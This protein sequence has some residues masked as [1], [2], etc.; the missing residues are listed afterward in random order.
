MKSYEKESFLKIFTIFFLT[1]VTLWGIIF[2]LYYEENKDY[3]KE[4]LYY[5]MKNYAFDFKGDKF[6]LEILKKKK[7]VT[8]SKLLNSKNGLEIYF[9]MPKE[10]NFML[11][12]KYSQKKFQS[13]LA[14]LKYKILKFAF[15]ILL[16]GF[17]FSLYFS[18]YSL[19]PMKKAISL[20]EVF[21]KDL[22]HDLHTPITS[23]LLNTK[24][25]SKKEPSQELERIELSAK[26]VSSLYKNL[27]VIK[28]RV[29]NKTEVSDIREII[30]QKIKILQKLYPKISIVSDLQ[31]YLVATNKDAIS[32]ILDNILTNACK[33][34]K[35][36]GQVKIIM[37][38]NKIV[39][40][41][42]GIGIKNPTKVFQRYYKE[43]ERGL[44]LGLNIVKKLCDELNINIDIKS[45][46]NIGT[47]VELTFN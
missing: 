4:D 16:F 11:K 34:N 42:N 15:V 12:V 31:D 23:I 5:Q 6:T 26:T 3:I 36:N 41:D 44:G 37:D 35:K 20:L 18:Y 21:L 39:I 30:I 13:D 25:L 8:F 45:K 40:K 2:Y 1:F 29:I 7:K 17:I 24:I 47:T 27:E 28:G 38:E 19:R 33:Y 14:K 9:P 46:I 32:R 10:D 43:N 22:I